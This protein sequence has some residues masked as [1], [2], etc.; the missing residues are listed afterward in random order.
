MKESGEKSRGSGCLGLHS[1]PKLSSTNVLPVSS[2]LPPTGWSSLS[3]D[4]RAVQKAAPGAWGCAEL[5]TT[6]CDFKFIKN[7][8]K[9]VTGEKKPPQPSLSAV[10]PPAQVAERVRSPQPRR[11]PPGAGT[12]RS[13]RGKKLG[14]MSWHRHLPGTR[15]VAAGSRFHNRLAVL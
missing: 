10:L 12:G 1:P 9:A 15:R 3:G 11:S 2:T 5:L 13:A 4:R 8:R 14:K 6:D 7:I